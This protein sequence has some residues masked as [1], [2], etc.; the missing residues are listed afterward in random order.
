MTVNYQVQQNEKG[1]ELNMSILC[2]VFYIYPLILD[3]GQTWEEGNIIT[4][5]QMKKVR[6]LYIKKFA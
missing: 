5:M 2:Y 4:F 3:S 6:L 1:G